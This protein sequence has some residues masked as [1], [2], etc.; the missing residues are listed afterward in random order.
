V[1]TIRADRRAA[2]LSVSGVGGDRY[3]F[4]DSF[5]VKEVTAA[6]YIDRRPQ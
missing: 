1:V 2:S 4:P 3:L 6:V 5:L